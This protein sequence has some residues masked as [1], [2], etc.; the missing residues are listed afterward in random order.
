[1]GDGRHSPTE[2]M[3]HY[4][5]ATVPTRSPAKPDFSFDDVP[6]TTYQ[7]VSSWTFTRS[8]GRR[9]IALCSVVSCLY[10]GKH[11]YRERSLAK[12]MEREIS[13]MKHSFADAQKSREESQSLLSEIKL[14][15]TEMQEIN[16]QMKH[17][18]KMLQAMLEEGVDVHAPSSDQGMESWMHA[19]QD[20]LRQH[21]H[22]LRRFLQQQ[23]RQALVERFGS[24][25][26][27]VEISVQ[28]QAS[29]EQHPSERQFVV[30]MASP[31]DLPHA[32]YFFL[33]TVDKQLWDD[34]VFLHHEQ[35]EHVVAAVP[36]EYDSQSIKQQGLSKL[37][38]QTMAF[39][40]YSNKHP[41]VKY[42]LGFANLGP[43]FYI[44]TADNTKMHGPGGQDHYR[45][46]EDADP[47]FARVVQGV[48]V[49]DSLVEYGFVSENRVDREGDHPWT[50]GEHAWSRIV[51]MRILAP[52]SAAETD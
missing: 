40:E 3:A 47:C 42:T 43:T 29:N 22:S 16:E 41:H 8:W 6:V 19:R 24:A 49:V 50:E 45:L 30:E 31:A 1:M 44:N 13:D 7:S 17:E 33:D 52:A 21:W 14:Q 37:E 5:V 51:S 48:E 23:S 39:P 35:V 28:I 12:A 34:T 9:L 32:V 27:Q 2:W 11:M 20:G 10:T 38:L 18:M 15:R 46:P 25:P 26:Y 4:P 36:L